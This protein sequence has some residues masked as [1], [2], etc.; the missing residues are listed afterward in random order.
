[1]RAA[2]KAISEI[3]PDANCPPADVLSFVPFSGPAFGRV[4]AWTDPRTARLGA[5]V[6]W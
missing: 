3:H 1:M 4:A 6:S 2:L 5:R